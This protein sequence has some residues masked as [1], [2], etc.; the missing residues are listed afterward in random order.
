MEERII[1]VI[2]RL[3]LIDGEVEKNIKL[4]SLGLDSLLKVE[5]VVQLEEEFN[6]TFNNEQ[7]NPNNF[8]TVQ[9]IIDLVKGC[10]KYDLE[11]NWKKIRKT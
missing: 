5:L 2:K 9:S 1:N 4:E 6:I 11:W 10:I 8:M 7:L 3:S